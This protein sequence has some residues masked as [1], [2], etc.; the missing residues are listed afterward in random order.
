VIVRISGEGQY[1]LDDSGIRKLDELDTA[2]TN[3]MDAGD[4]QEFHRLLKS[5]VEF[6]RQSGR[7]VPADTVVPSEV[8]VPP[9][10]T[11]MDEAKKFFT[12]E[13]LMAPLP[14]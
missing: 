8:I 11:T 1:E 7:E 2:L 6:I 13:G 4:E 9:D 3:A 12:D 5:T 10:D 14:A